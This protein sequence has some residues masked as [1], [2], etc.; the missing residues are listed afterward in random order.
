MLYRDIILSDNSHRVALK[1]SRDIRESSAR[2][3]SN[4]PWVGNNAYYFNILQYTTFILNT[5]KQGVEPPSVRRHAAYLTNTLVMVRDVFT[6]WY[7]L[8]S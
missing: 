1:F 2:R 3:S 5:F 8:V 6:R 7:I 4:L